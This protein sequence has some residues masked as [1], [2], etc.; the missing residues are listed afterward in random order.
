MYELLIFVFEK[1]T[2][3]C[4]YMPSFATTWCTKTQSVPKPG[5]WLHNTWLQTQRPSQVGCRNCG[6]GPVSSLPLHSP[7]KK[8]EERATPVLSDVLADLRRQETSAADGYGL[9]FESL[10][11]LSRGVSQGTKLWN[12]TCS[13]ASFPEFTPS[14]ASISPRAGM[15]PAAIL[16]AVLRPSPCPSHGWG[17]R[18]SLPTSP[19][20][21]LCEPL[22]VPCL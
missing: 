1:L 13:M 2:G 11:P 19:R 14:G 15:L 6:H 5:F 21:G 20:G 4:R 9:F 3:C 22:L 8:E 7:S 12:L 10:L 16:S 18:G 17:L